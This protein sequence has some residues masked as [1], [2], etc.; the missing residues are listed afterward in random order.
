MKAK[1]ITYNNNSKDYEDFKDGEHFL[2]LSQTE[3]D[4]IDLVTKNFK[5]VTLVYQRRQRVPL[6][7][8]SQYPQ[9]KSVRGAR[10]PARRLLRT[11]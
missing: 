10:R 7:F 1:G 3:R 2:Q 11:G 6:D 4:M 5:K 8:L 9:I